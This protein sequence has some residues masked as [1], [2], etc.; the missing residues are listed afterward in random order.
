M[1]ATTAA[2]AEH[3]PPR[4]CTNKPAQFCR[5]PVTTRSSPDSTTVQV[6]REKKIST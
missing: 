4:P 5:S 2:P 3:W 6:I 1:L